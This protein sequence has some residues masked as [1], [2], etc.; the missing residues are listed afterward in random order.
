MMKKILKW[1]LKELILFILGGCTY[2][3][4]ELC[5][6]GH[7]HYSMGIVGGI[8][9]VLVGLINEFYEW[10]MPFCIQ[11]VIGGTTITC[12][13]LVSGVIL[14]IILDLHIWDYSDQPFNLLGQICLGFSIYWYLICIPAI[15]L[16]DYIRYYLFHEEKP[17]Y[18]W[19]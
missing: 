7:T 5:Y 9:F 3:I 10:D 15:I 19:V 14:N 2:M 13:E 8:C 11:V 4:I 16:D 12:I 18:K 17:H 6:R 1:L